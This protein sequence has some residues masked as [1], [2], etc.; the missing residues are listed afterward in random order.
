MSSVTLSTFPPEIRQHI[1]RWVPC[2]ET[3][4]CSQV[5][6]SL[7]EDVQTAATV[8]QFDI[9]L[10]RQWGTAKLDEKDQTIPALLLHKMKVEAL[11]AFFTDYID[12]QPEDQRKGILKLHTTPGL[13]S[14]PQA[15]CDFTTKKYTAENLV[16]LLSVFKIEPK[17]QRIFAKAIFSHPNAKDMPATD[18][19]STLC[20]TI[21]KKCHVNVGTG[22]VCLYTIVPP[23]AQEYGECRIPKLI[24]SHPKAKEMDLKDHIDVALLCAVRYR[25]P[26]LVQMVLEHPDAKNLLDSRIEDVVADAEKVE[27][28]KEEIVSALTKFKDAPNKVAI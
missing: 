17:F 19:R 4:R 1:L 23:D 7:L 25:N 10:S 27:K 21:G 3:H 16:N 9:S 2:V 14:S 24:F 12:Q 15:V 5:V 11:A 22:G 26:T 6:K 20:T 28:N 13:I 8:W 18:L